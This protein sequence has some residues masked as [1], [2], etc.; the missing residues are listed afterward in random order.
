MA[1]RSWGGQ[2]QVL[3]VVAALVV[4]LAAQP[5]QAGD[6]TGAS[7]F[8]SG[9]HTDTTRS[10]LSSLWPDPVTDVVRQVPSLTGRITVGAKTLL[11]YIGAGFG[12]GYATERDRALNGASP[13]GSV[14]LD[15]S[16][17]VGLLP[18]EVQMGIRFPF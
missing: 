4:G 2:R 9:L 15:R 10:T 6:L 18:N 12:G 17:A 3:A 1:G 13:L 16:G 11:P 5:S 14:P 8:W 7:S